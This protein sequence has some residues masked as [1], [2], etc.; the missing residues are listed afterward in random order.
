MS[1]PRI[2]DS[3]LGGMFTF[4]F[5]CPSVLVTS[6]RPLVAYKYGQGFARVCAVKY[7]SDADEL[8]NNYVHLT[9]ISI[10]KNGVTI[11]PNFN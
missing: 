2:A 8:D 4:F 11:F 9:N 3:T 1:V 10:Q 7:T 5:T 6:W